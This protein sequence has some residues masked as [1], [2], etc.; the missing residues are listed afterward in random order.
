MVRFN[1]NLNRPFFKK[2][3]SRTEVRSVFSFYLDSN[4]C[5]LRLPYQR[6]M[7]TTFNGELQ[8]FVACISSRITTVIQV[9]DGSTSSGL[10]LI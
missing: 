8:S 7:N 2:N 6:A 9:S 1:Q 4:N 5:A 3:V 10:R